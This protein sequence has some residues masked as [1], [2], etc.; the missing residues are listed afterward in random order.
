MSNIK[1]TIRCKSKDISINGEEMYLRLLAINAYK[2]VPLERVMA[3]E[4]ATVPLSLFS[5]SGDMVTTKKSDFL[6]KLENLIEP[7]LIFRNVKEADCI[8]FDGMAIIQMLQPPQSTVKLVYNDMASAFWKYILFASEGVHNIHVVF[9]RYIEN[10]LKFQ[11][12]E[13]RGEDVSR[14]TPTRIQGKMNFPDWKR[15]LANSRFKR[16]LTN[17]YTQYLTEHC[18]EMLSHTQHVY[19]SG[20]LQAKALEVS[21]EVIEFV[22]QLR[23]NHEEADTRML[24]HGASQARSGVNRVVVASPDT[25]VFVLLVHHYK[26]MSIDQIFFKQEGKAF[27]RTLPDLFLCTQWPDNLVKNKQT[28]C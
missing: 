20:G 23:S 19:V 4:I 16:R 22:K 17:L 15:A 8:V 3:F 18:H 1:A 24:L 14:H 10:S 7:E 13:K 9:D 27:I 6:D 5:D 12:R 28:Y 11:T 25:D 2:K 26:H 21:F